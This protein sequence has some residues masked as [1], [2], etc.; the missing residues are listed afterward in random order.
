MILRV[1]LK[2]GKIQFVEMMK[3]VKFDDKCFSVHFYTR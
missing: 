3:K 2:S 1:V